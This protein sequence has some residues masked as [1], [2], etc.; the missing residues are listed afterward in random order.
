LLKLSSCRLLRIGAA[1]GHWGFSDVSRAV[2]PYPHARCF[3]GMGPKPP[4][5]ECYRPGCPMPAG[6]L[7]R[8]LTPSVARLYARTRSQRSTEDDDNDDGRSAPQAPKPLVLRTPP[9]CSCPGRLR[10]GSP[11]TLIMSRPV[12]QRPD[13]SG[14]DE[15]L[16]SSRRCCDPASGW[17]TG[18]TLVY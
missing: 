7:A 4:K 17:M 1:A 16:R 14:G 15:T 6:I 9:R 2:R 5:H 3:Y 18:M 8:I 12:P 10:Q 11:G 13:K